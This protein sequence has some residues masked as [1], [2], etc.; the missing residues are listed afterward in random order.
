[1]PQPL[2]RGRREYVGLYSSRLIHRPMR[3][4]SSPVPGTRQNTADV[5]VLLEGKGYPTVAASLPSVGATATMAEDAAAIGA[6]TA[7][8]VA[9]GKPV[10]LVMHSYG[11]IP[12]A[13]SA[14]GLARK[15]RWHDEIPRGGIVALVYLAAYMLSAGMSVMSFGGGGAMPAWL[16]LEICSNS[17]CKQVS[18]PVPH[19]TSHAGWK[20]RKN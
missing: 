19:P 4:S 8:L 12:G 17:R 20:G 1:M 18:S 6:L 2:A 9:E 10:V 14:R 5:R 15:D 13:E 7:Q 11:E 3:S 16:F